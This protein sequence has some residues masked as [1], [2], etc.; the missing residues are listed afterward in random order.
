MPNHDIQE[1]VWNVLCAE[2]RGKD[3]AISGRD[4]AV[5]MGTTYGMVRR[6]I[7]SLRDHKGKPIA[8]FSIA[9]DGGYYVMTD[10]DDFLKCY[11]MMRR[12]GIGTLRNARRMLR[13]AQEQVYGQGNLFRVN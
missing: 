5:K 13:A 3:R 10:P 12:Q 1:A 6:A 7:R 2:H 8:A 4:L 11:R 9:Q